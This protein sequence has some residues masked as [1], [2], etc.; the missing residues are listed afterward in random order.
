MYQLACAD[1]YK[2]PGADIYVLDILPVMAGFAATASDQTLS[3]VDPVRLSQGPIK[4][5]RTNHGNLITA[6]VYSE[7]SSVICTAGENGTISVW[8]MRRDPAIA[9]EMQIGGMFSQGPS[10]DWSTILTQR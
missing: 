1:G 2:Y 6:K 3:L 7:A 8:D 10:R 5:I 4:K 9:L